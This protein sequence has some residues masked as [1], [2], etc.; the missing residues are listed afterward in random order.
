MSLL[1]FGGA[2]APDP[3]PLL[4]P[5]P[6]AVPAAPISGSRIL[7]ADPDRATMTALA[8][9]FEMAGLQVCRCET[10]M[11]LRSRLQN[12]PWDVL[13]LDPRVA[14][15]ESVSLFG[16]IA[17]LPAP[18]SLIVTG[19]DMGEVD[20]IVALE[21]GADHCVPKPCSAAEMLAR[22]RALLVRQRARSVPAAAAG[23]AVFADLVFEPTRR[24]LRM[25]DGRSTRLSA[26]EADL[27][28]QFLRNPHKVLTRDDL[29]A[30]QAPDGAVRSPRAIDVQVSRLRHA[31][32]SR[33]QDVIQTVRGR[34]YSLVY[35]VRWE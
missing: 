22:V 14:G 34:G 15:S 23:R 32:N 12:G 19:P 26:S 27:L 17:R 8:Q 16:E 30:A 35:D 3:V 7:I 11:R 29:L 33:F 21:L 20:R 2:G 24:T 28:I 4:P 31:L 1:T 9:T 5:R 25:T 13:V 18:P 6:A 10:L